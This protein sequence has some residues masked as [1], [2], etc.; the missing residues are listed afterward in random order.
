MNETRR[1]GRTVEMPHSKMTLLAVTSLQDIWNGFFQWSLWGR[2]GWLEIKR[3]Y[4]RTVVGPFWTSVSL[5]VFVL[6]MS[7]VG[8][9]LL[10]KETSTYLPFLVAGMVV[11]N[12]LA[13]I[14]Q[15]SSSVFITGAGLLR[16]TRFNYS[17]LVYALIWRNLIVFFHNMI[18]YFLIFLLFAPGKLT[19]V[20]FLA[21]PGLVII[22]LNGAWIALLIGT[23]AARF[24]DIQQM[25]QTLLQIS[26]FI[27]PIF[28]PPESLSGL[29]RIFFVGLNPL[30]HL[31]SIVRDPLLGNFPRANNYIAAILITI[32]GWALMLYTFK[33]FRK[34]ISY[35][36]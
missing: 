18:V 31:V 35:W 15:E 11:W 2:L 20:N 16:Q 10:S 14:M 28:W 22:L 12:L 34:R 36:I 24:R 5:L 17:V 19:L 8:S 25:M 32:A 27:T 23:I 4:R 29:R 6:V 1:D 26:M 33:K 21:I 7:A 9:G 30:Y 3:R 13:S